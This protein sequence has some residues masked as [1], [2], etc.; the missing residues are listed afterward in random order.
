VRSL[1]QI[2]T[3]IMAEDPVVSE[4][5]LWKIPCNREKYRE[6]E[7]ISAGTVTIEFAQNAVPEPSFSLSAPV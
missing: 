1:E 2:L 7:A 4:T 3:K 6:I 5:V